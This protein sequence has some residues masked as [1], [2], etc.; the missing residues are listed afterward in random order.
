[1]RGR[2]APV[3]DAGGSDGVD[4]DDGAAVVRRRSERDAQVRTGR[5]VDLDQQGAGRVLH[6]LCNREAQKIRWFPK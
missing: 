1:M 4:T 3:C 2:H 5:L 6:R